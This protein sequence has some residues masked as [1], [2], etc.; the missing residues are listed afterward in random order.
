ME[1]TKFTTT[2]S[3]RYTLLIYKL[4]KKIKPQT[5]VEIIYASLE[6]FAEKE[7]IDVKEFFK[8]L[9]SV[10]YKKEEK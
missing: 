8:Q 9:N 4:A 5:I 2:I 1:K 7:G 6:Y 10:R 3:K